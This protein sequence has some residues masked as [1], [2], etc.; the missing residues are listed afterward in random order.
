MVSQRDHSEVLLVEDSDGDAL[1][2]E[3]YLAEVCGA[4]VTRASRVDAAAQLLRDRS[5]DFVISDLAL[6][7]A[8]GLDAVRQLQPLAPTTPLI[9]ITG[10]DDEELAIQ[11]MQHGA[12]DY[13]VK[14]QLDASILR[15][16]LRH[17]TERKRICNRLVHL[18]R[19]DPLTGVGNRAA[20]RD[21]IE[22]ALARGR[23]HA[24]AFAVLFIDLDRFKA[25][26]DTL[27][28]DAG[29]LVLIEIAARIG[30][31]VRATD[32]V[33]RLGGD[34]FAVLLDD[35]EP[36]DQPLDVGRRILC[37]I[38]RPIALPG[39]E[40]V[41]TGSIG[42]ACY[43]EVSGT[44]DDLL[45]AADS[46]MYLAK[47]R[48]RNNIQVVG[49]V[50]AEERARLAMIHDLQHALER[51]ELGL[52]FQPQLTVDHRHVVA[53][54]ALLR[55]HRPNAP[56]V[57]PAEFVP[58]LEDSGRIAAVGAWVLDRACAQLASWRAAGWR[59]LRVAVNLSARQFDD[60]HFVELVVDCLRRHDVPARC[61]ELELTE[62]VLMGDTARVTAML[63]ELR[64]LGTRIALDD[65]GTGYSSLA[66][67]SRFQVDCLKIDRS[68]IEHVDVDRERALIASAIVSLGH[69][70]GLEVVAEGVESPEQ[71]AFVER[72]R[73]DLV[74]GFLFGR[75]A[76]AEHVALARCS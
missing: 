27:G 45:K 23:R 26:N 12:Q 4:L 35:L 53:Y 20:L 44:A 36:G 51:G 33:A 34:E 38:E 61:L 3:E 32:L 62:T 2:F 30:Q 10:L 16:T 50:N 6:P 42:M 29:D 40:I 28:H 75:P 17:A 76:A 11:A 9:V 60:D 57:S 13:L 52:H 66:Y 63:G 68:F 65:F 1:L 31:C 72:E 21:R 48:G 56:A 55:W 49:V 5:F 22:T 43:P 39:G 64:A 46:A 37:G 7:D 24:V 59:D 19:H 73:C 25:I 15:R 8:R 67:L 18:S 58:L 14:G 41:V 69:H 74:Q 47:R 71:L 70:L 54:E